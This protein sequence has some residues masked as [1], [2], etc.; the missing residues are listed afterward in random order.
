MRQR[1]G[2]GDRAGAGGKAALGPVW[3]AISPASPGDVSPALRLPVQ[4]SLRCGSV[5]CALAAAAAGLGAWL[6]GNFQMR[7]KIQALVPR[8]GLQGCCCRAF[9]AAAALAGL[10]ALG[11]GAR[12]ALAA[13]AGGWGWC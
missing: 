1:L 3:R 5:A 12:L 13:R 6:F 9:G 4:S 8:C 7:S 10:G 2:E 11:A